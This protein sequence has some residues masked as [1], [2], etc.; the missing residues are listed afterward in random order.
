V[1]IIGVIASILLSLHLPVSAVAQRRRTS[2]VRSAAGS[3]CI[4]VMPRPNS[5]GVSLSNPAGG[6]RSFN[7]SIQVDDLPAE[8]VSF[9]G[10]K[11]IGG[12][13][14]GKS[15]LVKIR[16]EGELVQSFKFTFKRYSSRDLCL[17]FKPLYET[18]Q[19][20]EAKESAAAR[21]ECER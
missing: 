18:W 1:K 6:N 9:D 5:G 10:G 4:A 17:W 21:C 8:E 15:H 2:S 3:I 13:S 16:R 19:L 11:L 12:L 20:W 7:F 14:L